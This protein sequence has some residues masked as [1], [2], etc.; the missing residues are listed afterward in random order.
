M[1][2]GWPSC[3]MATDWVAGAEQVRD[4][5]TGKSLNELLDR[6][7]ILQHVGNCLVAITDIWLARFEND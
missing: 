6:R 5:R 1:A 3:E 4:L 7:Q 2:I